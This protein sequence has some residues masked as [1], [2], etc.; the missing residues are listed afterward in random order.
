MIIGIIGNGFVGNATKL[1]KSSII[2]KLYVYDIIPEK[3]EPVNLSFDKLSE[4]DIIFIAVP[5]PMN[6]DGSCNTDIVEK[7]IKSLKKIIDPK[8]TSIIVR[9]T[10]VPGTCD[11][12]E[13]NFMPEFLTE[14]NWYDDFINCENWIIGCN[15][16]DDIFKDKIIK[17]LNI[18]YEE[19]LIKHNNIHFTSKNIA[20]LV[21]Y[22]RNCFLATKISFF[23]EIE[24]FCK[25]SNINYENVRFLSTL[26]NRIN[27]NHSYVPGHDGINGFGG[28]CFPKD[29][30][31]LLCEMDRINMQ[32][33]IIKATINRNITDRIR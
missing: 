18:A 1:I 22:V 10:V 27:T 29:V 16:S 28:T 13:V 24:E 23:N 21:K 11:R 3:S 2:E 4:C 31:A 25:K 32:S 26:D 30:N 19:K 15:L 9:S 8:I 12:L 20:E 6:N 33:H 5:T 17:I 14:K 7:C